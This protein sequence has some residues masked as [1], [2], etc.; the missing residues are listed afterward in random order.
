MP[1]P[2]DVE[3]LERVLA[4]ARRGSYAFPGSGATQ[5]LKT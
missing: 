5:L 2:T 1:V 4:L 3:A